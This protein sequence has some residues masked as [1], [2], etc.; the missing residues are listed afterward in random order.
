MDLQKINA[1][2]HGGDAAAPSSYAVKLDL[3]AAFHFQEGSFS[4]PDASKVSS[5]AAASVQNATPSLGKSAF[6]L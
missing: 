6:S 5:S 4:P 1:M 3:N 2:S